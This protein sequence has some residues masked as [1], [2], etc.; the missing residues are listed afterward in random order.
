MLHSAQKHVFRF[1][2]LD[3][4]TA[5]SSSIDRVPVAATVAAAVAAQINDV[6]TRERAVR[7]TAF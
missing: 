7:T 5:S 6:I 2:S 4:R 3:T 1:L